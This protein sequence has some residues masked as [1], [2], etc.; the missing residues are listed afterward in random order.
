MKQVK[1]AGGVKSPCPAPAD[2]FEL[3]ELCSMEVPEMELSEVKELLL[4]RQ[5]LC[6]EILAMTEV[7]SFT[8]GSNPDELE[9]E[10]TKFAN[11]YGKREDIM[12]ELAA[13]NEQIGETGFKLA[14]TD[15][16][17]V[18][19]L[20]E[21]ESIIKQI[22][23]L[24]KRHRSIGTTLFDS[25]KSSIK[26]VKDGRNLTLKYSGDYDDVSGANLDNKN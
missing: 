3:Y 8:F 1:V 7:E 23:E 19:L 25:I 17:A 2:L 14:G 16:E 5:S 10:T 6:K 11:L 24:D 4:R 15:S 26:R 13:V 21:T 9:A 18:K 20:N 12:S 22:L